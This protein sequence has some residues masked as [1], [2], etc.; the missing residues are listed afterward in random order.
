MKLLACVLSIAL[1]PL[2]GR[3]ADQSTSRASEAAPAD[4]FV[5]PFPSWTNL[6]TA[7]H[8][9]GDGVADDSA[10]IQDA[11]NALGRP[12]RS[13]VL[14]IPRGTYRI[15]RTLTLANVINVS[16]VG[17]DP[18]TTA[19]VWDGPPGG[20]MLSVNGV[21]YSR[22]VRL[23]LDGRRRASAAVDQSYD[24]VRPHFDTGNEYAD[25]RF[26]D[27]GHGI[28]GGFKGNGFA[29]TSVVRSRFIRNTTAGISLGNFNALDLWVWD[30]TF[31]DCGAGVTNA[32]GAGNFRVYNSVF[33]RSTIGDLVMGNTGGFSARGNYSV[34]S[35]A[36]FVT[37]VTKAYPATIHLQRNT[38]VDT[39]SAIAIEMRNQGP[40]VLSD[41]TIRSARGAAGPVVRW[42]VGGGADVVSIGNT[43]T[44]ADAVAVNGR[45]VSIDDRVV[46]RDDVPVAEPVLPATPPSRSRPVIEAAAP[47]ART[48]D[49]QKAIDAAAAQKGR[50]PIVHVPYGTYDIAATITIPASD[51]QIVG[52]GYATVLRWTGRGRGP[53]LRVNGPTTATLREIQLDGGGSVDTVAVSGIDQP[54]SRAYLQEV[55]LRSGKQADLL[56]AGLAH[57]S[58]DAR[59]IGHA[60]SPSGTSITVNGANRTNIFSGAS[61]GNAN[62]YDVSGG[63]RVL[64]RDVWYE[65][66]TGAAFANIHDR[67][68]FTIDGSR[69]ASPANGAQ[70][71]FTIAGLNG[72]VAILASH[73][74]DRIAVSGRG[75]DARV[76]ALAVFDEQTPP[77]FFNTA[78][79]PAK[80][81]LINSRHKRPAGL[82]SWSIATADMGPADNALVIR[83][84]AHTRGEMP[85]P[86]ADLAAGV[87]DLRMFR[88][89]LANGQVNLALRP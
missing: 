70:P 11:L 18:A 27:A 47:G 24:G 53:L 19:I 80:A 38:I 73:I 34:G 83:L 40:A 46:S 81:L 84:L 20:T 44:T 41:N 13:P 87:T 35:Q 22:F 67:A 51:V 39:R 72:D 42:N 71:A 54:G 6:R 78:D 30:S 63:A 4:E 32:A 77:Y 2:S 52:D 33:H 59:D 76:L 62:T 48:I 26:V 88:V 49:V 68:T 12:D 56:V 64:V 89:W 58:V 9:I 5:G 66:N 86:L 69:V 29:E 36:F 14:Y 7:H 60:Y 15:T 74:D 1:I 10:P 75:S 21:A 85:G 25:D 79:P 8:A 31:D 37:S 3:V 65:S 17:E 45:L 16:I 43:F 50:R 55:Q 28:R 82:G 23:T 61:S 57:T